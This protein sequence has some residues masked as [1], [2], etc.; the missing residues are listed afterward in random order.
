M[1]PK[2]HVKSH[3]KELFNLISHKRNELKMQDY[4]FQGKIYPIESSIQLAQ[5]QKLRIKLRRHNS[6]TLRT[7]NTRNSDNN[8][9][10]TCPNNWI[11]GIR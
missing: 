8:L 2:K 4:N 7:P 10:T 5:V 11:A 3:I 6:R 1:D 9:T